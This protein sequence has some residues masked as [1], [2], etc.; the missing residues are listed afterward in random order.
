[1]E[2]ASVGQFTADSIHI[3]LV[4]ALCKHTGVKVAVGAFGLAERNL[5]VDAEIHCGREF[6]WWPP[7]APGR[8]P[9]SVAGYRRDAESIQICQERFSRGAAAGAGRRTRK[10]KC[11]AS[12][13][14]RAGPPR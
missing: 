11:L 5:N 2:G 9:S 14:G 13:P 4:Q 1:M 10:R 12:G 3:R 8:A 6:R 7:S